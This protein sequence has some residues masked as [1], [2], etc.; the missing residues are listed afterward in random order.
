MIDIFN[1]YIYDF[2]PWLRFRELYIIVIIWQIFTFSNK[3][4]FR[5]FLMTNKILP[6]HQPNFIPNYLILYMHS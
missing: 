2:K 6:A 4:V 5:K 1:L 3:L